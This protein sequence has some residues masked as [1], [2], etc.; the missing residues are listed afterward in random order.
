MDSESYRLGCLICDR[1]FEAGY[2]AYFAG[3]WVR[4]FIL[5]QESDEIDIATSAPPL[6]I[7]KLFPKTIPVGIQFGVVIAVL[8]GINF[9]ISTFRKDHP[10][11]DGRHPE[12]VDFSTAEKDAQRRD[13]TINGMF[14]DPRT[15]K[16]YDFVGGQ[17]DLKQKIIRA[18]GD[19]F[20]R[21]N[22]DRLRM[23]RAVRFSARFDFT[24]ERNSQAAIR[25]LAYTLFPAVSMERIW[26]EFC[27]MAAFPTKM[28]PALLQLH[29][30]SLLG[31]IF[32]QIGHLTTEE[33]KK[34][35]K[36][37]GSFPSNLPPILYLMELFCEFSLKEKE[38]LCLYLK[39]TLNDR[40]LIA[41]FHHA[42]N[43]FAKPLIEPYE[44]AHFY[45]SPQ[46]PLFIEF[47]A[48]KMSQKKAS[49]YLNEHTARRRELGKH[50]ERI[51]NKNPLITSKDLEKYG[52]GPGIQMGALLK[53]AEKIAINQ[54]LFQKEEVLTQLFLKR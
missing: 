11:K 35:V 30:L 51:K 19:P 27:K 41:F 32:P 31:V 46:A 26:Q 8:E 45:A 49:Y 20:A 40:K 43:L 47:A 48:A 39:T 44:W 14:Y 2:T 12:G 9:E 22:E 37:M 21:F 33:I 38:E 25:S 1:L 34:R 3:G 24:I 23:V 13:F 50:I 36:Y 18:I 16:I 5:G 42:S 4:D 7:Q 17:E 54:N 6:V 10:Y 29:K 52:I 28:G 15:E 53:K